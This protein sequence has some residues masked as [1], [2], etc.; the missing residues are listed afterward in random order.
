MRLEQWRNSPELCQWL[1][2][3]SSGTQWQLLLEMLQDEHPM[4]T[5]LAP[6]STESDNLRHL[7]HIEGYQMA[8]ANLRIASSP[9][10]E[11]AKPLEATFQPQE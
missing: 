8:I 9:P 3:I 11:E 5:M 7:G 4:H 2:G 1:G 6:G 10:M